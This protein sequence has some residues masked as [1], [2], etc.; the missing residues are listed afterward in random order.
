[1]ESVTPGG[2]PQET[3]SPREVVTVIRYVSPVTTIKDT[4]L[5]FALEVPEEW[6][7]TTHRLNNPDTTEGLLYQTDL[8][9][10]TFTLVTYAISRGQDQNYR[11][12]FRQWS[13][14]PAETT[15]VINDITFDRFESASPGMTTIAYVARKASANERGYASVLLFTVNSTDRFGKEDYEKVA[16]SFRY[17]EGATAGSV[18]G[19][20]IERVAPPRDESGSMRS[21]VGSGS[22]GSSGGSSS[23]GCSRCRG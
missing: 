5:L 20:E 7:V 23:G 3:G 1:M 2:T 4:E 18:P 9:P 15:V 6:R 8:V 14:A 16:A 12:R 13:P 10:D 17:L 19:R 21:A 22:S 11:D